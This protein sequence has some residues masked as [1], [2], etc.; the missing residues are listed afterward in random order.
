MIVDVLSFSTSGKI[1][2]N[3]GA[4]IFPYK[5]KDESALEIMPSHYRR[6]HFPT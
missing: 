1:A 6:P 5:W 3:N 2:T 4:I